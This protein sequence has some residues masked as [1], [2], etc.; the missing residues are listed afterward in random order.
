LIV[1]D[2]NLPGEDGISLCR[3]VG[4]SRKIPIIMLTAR[5]EPIDR[6]IGLEVGAD[7]YLAKPFE[8][9][10]LLARIR[11]VLRRSGTASDP[12]DIMHA[13]RAHFRGWSLDFQNRCLTD[14]NGRVVM[15]SGNEFSLLKFLVE[16]ANDV[17]SRDQLLT[18]ASPEDASDLSRQRLADIQIFRLRQKLHRDGEQSPLIV[19]VRNSGYVLAA[20]VKFE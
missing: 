16:N 5:G 11:S 2:L 6:V 14:R 4:Q 17:L 7:D 13:R 10:E 19:T 1:L 18:L 15:L 9:R 3:R 8:P 12:V 20:A